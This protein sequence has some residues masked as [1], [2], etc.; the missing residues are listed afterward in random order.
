[1]LRLILFAAI[2]ILSACAGGAAA[3]VRGSAT[4]RP[5]GEER[6]VDSLLASMTLEEKLGQLNQITAA[7]Y[8]STP[9]S[10]AAMIKRGGVGSLMDAIGADT[11]RALQRLAVEK[12]RLHIPL[13]FAD[14]VI[15]GFRTI[16]PIPLGE[17]ASWNPSLAERSARVAAIESAANGIVWTYAPMVDVARDPRW[18]RIMEGA[19][20]D[21]FLGAAFAAARVRGFQG[22]DLRA[23]T[24]I[25]ATAKHFAAYGAAEGG[26]DYN[27]ADVSERTLREVYFPPFH[28]A[29][30]AGVQ[31]V[32]ASF[33]DIG[34]IPSHANRRLLTD[35]LRGEW[36]FDGTLVSD[37]NGVV[38]LLPHGVAGDRAT[39]GALALQAGVDIDMVSQ[40]Y[41]RD[42]APLVQSGRVSERE[43]DEAVRRVLRLKYRLG[44]FVDPYHG[45][46][47]ARAQAVTLTAANRAAARQAARES[48]VLLENKGGVL[49][50]RRDIGTV[51]VIGALARDSASS[52]GAWAAR[53]R[54][55]DAVTVL[56]GI[57]RAVSPQTRVQYARGASPTG[58]DT[59]GIA[60]AVRLARQS[61]AAILVIGESREMTGEASSRASLDLPGA[62]Q[63]LAEAVQATGKPVVVVLMNGRPLAISWLHDHV[64][65]ILETWYGGVEAGN[66]TADVLFGAYNP[67]GKLPV[68]FPRAVGQVPIY[69][70]HTNTGRPSSADNSY[71]SKYIDLPWTPLY[72]LGHGLSYT[73]F[74]LGV[75]R[76]SATILR[77]GDSLDVTVD[78]AN[79]GS[80]AGDQVVQLYIRDDV[81]S[82]TRPTRELRG[83]QRV[84]L[85]PHESRTVHFVIRDQALAFY[86]TSM[87]RVVEPGTFTVSTGGDAVHTS[88]AQFRFDTPNGN[89]LRVPERCDGPRSSTVPAETTTQPPVN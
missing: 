49:P 10:L 52:I 79:A 83:F 74:T 22:D 20:E 14:D 19:G 82:V 84:Q 4:A 51:A 42:L 62:Q 21:P 75:P 85:A 30:C 2:A 25:A 67:G 81:A 64:P 53:A 48:I 16:F 72:P 71:T 27:R 70:A 28:A 36:H 56:E 33:N 1:M 44:L 17:A 29:V 6:F 80:V 32:M 35:I 78:V 31:T 59:S 38:E 13:V 69:A 41:V 18:G 87:T 15:H 57:R 3:A 61:D 77:P 66:A 12:T 39:A 89:P 24:A 60:E 11:T 73:T 43:V 68:T 34:G 63:R 8:A 46:D 65:A 76:L 58:D 5:A 40:I 7:D 26:R 55:V 23:P 47:A 54:E 86:D 88:Q 9:D 50:L 37:W 45:A